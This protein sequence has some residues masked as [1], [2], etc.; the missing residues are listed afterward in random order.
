MLRVRVS[1]L[2]GALEVL[3]DHSSGSLLLDQ[4]AASAVKQWRFVPA[5]RGSDAVEAWV[6]VPVDFNLRN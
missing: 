3:V 4:A 1:G 2:G 6:L 5:R